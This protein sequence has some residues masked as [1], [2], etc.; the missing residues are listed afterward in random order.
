MKQTDLYRVENFANELRLI[1]HHVSSNEEDFYN[2]IPESDSKD[3]SSFGTYRRWENGKSKPDEAEL[4]IIMR[5][6]ARRI[7]D[8]FQV[9][10]AEKLWR[11]RGFGKLSE[12]I[13][14]QI[15]GSNQLTPLDSS[16]RYQAKPDTLPM[17]KEEN[18]SPC[19]QGLNKSITC[20]QSGKNPDCFCNQPAN[21]PQKL[22]QETIKEPQALELGKYPGWIT[23]LAWSPDAH[24]L[25]AVITP[26]MGFQMSMQLA[27]LLGI[28]KSVELSS[29]LVILDFNSQQEVKKELAHTGWI[30][31]V[32]WNKDGNWLATAGQD[33]I[34][35]IWNTHTWEAE[36]IEI[37]QARVLHVRFHPTAPLI[38]S[39][40]NEGC[41]LVWD[42]LQKKITGKYKLESGKQA[43]SVAWLGEGHRLAVGSADGS[44]TLLDSSKPTLVWKL[45]L[46]GQ[47]EW[48]WSITASPCG[49]FIA[50]RG[51]SNNIKIWQ[52]D[53]PG[54]IEKITG[55]QETINCLEWSPTG[56]FLA[57][58]GDEGII[59]IWDTTNWQVRHSI[60]F[61]Q[62]SPAW[63]IIPGAKDLNYRR[64]IRTVRWTPDGKSL[65]AAGNDGRVLVWKII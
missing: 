15:F 22:N 20:S 24:R 48:I 12:D 45:R 51:K 1:R 18:N 58:A 35:R 17:A 49:K 2:Q 52:D 13:K 26:G 44:I 36:S 6:F 5:Y 41:V 55:F 8:Y 65:A 43:T 7:P 4:I 32:D 23:G 46:I 9:I 31:T 42:Y 54:P 63:Q 21:P 50:S 47:G 10:N 14:T 33:K 53:Y 56:R 28:K 34:L 29:H 38:A 19:S 25:A 30:D 40:D 37:N 60:N 3:F 61:V 27:S 57:A 16:K 62:H 11:L 39:V 64:W 59:I